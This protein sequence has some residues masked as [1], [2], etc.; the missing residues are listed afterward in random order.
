MDAKSSR[1]EAV[2]RMG[3]LSEE[4]LAL[5]GEHEI[6]VMLLRDHGDQSV[7]AVCGATAEMVLHMARTALECVPMALVEASP[8]DAKVSA[9]TAVFNEAVARVTAEHGDGESE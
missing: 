1:E 9:I 7:C 6:P 8:L 2:A 4:L 3:V 5:A